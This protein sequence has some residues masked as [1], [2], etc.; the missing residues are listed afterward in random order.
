MGHANKDYFFVGM[1]LVL[2]KDKATDWVCGTYLYRQKSN[3]FLVSVA[4][5]FKEM[6]F[7]FC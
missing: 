1:R 2:R 4:V 7:A 6:V 3:I 5:T